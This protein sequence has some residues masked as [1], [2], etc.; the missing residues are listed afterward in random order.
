[1]SKFKR[2]KKEIDKEENK[3]ELDRYLDEDDDGDF[4]SDFDVL[5]WWKLN[6]YRFLIVD[7]PFCPRFF[8]FISVKIGLI[9][10]QKIFILMRFLDKISR[11]SKF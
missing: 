9:F 7:I 8:R 2:Y 6:S 5:I 3:T 4:D 10:E 11:K 1:M